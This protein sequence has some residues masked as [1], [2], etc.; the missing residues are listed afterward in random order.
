MLLLAVIASAAYFPLLT[1]AVAR[2]APRQTTQLPDWQQYAAWHAS[3]HYLV[4]ED[5]YWNCLR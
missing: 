3:W 2:D 5:E 1:P 4:L